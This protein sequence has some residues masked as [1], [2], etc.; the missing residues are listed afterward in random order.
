MDRRTSRC[1]IATTSARNVSGDKQLPFFTMTF[2]SPPFQRRLLVALFV[3]V[4]VEK[5]AGGSFIRPVATTRLPGYQGRAVS[6]LQSGGK[7]IENTPIDMEKLSAVD[8]EGP[9]RPGDQPTVVQHSFEKEV[10]RNDAMLAMGTS[11]R[12]IAISLL[13]AGGIALAGN[14][15]GVT[16]LILQTMDENTVEATGLDTFYPRGDYKRVRTPDYTFVIPKDWVADTSLELAKSQR[17][18]QPL[19]YAINKGR[20]GVLPDCG[21]SVCVC[22]GTELYCTMWLPARNNSICH[23]DEC[24]TFLSCSLWSTRAAGFTRGIKA[25]YECFR[26]PVESRAGLFTWRDDENAHRRCRISARECD[27]TTSRRPRNTLG[28]FRE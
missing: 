18:A 11:P 28:R 10:T 19:D 24:L 25:Y 14:L 2:S 1:D 16:S 4:F 22:V 15:F 3:F 27:W 23:A 6:L 5:C 20:S 12:R 17:M 13:S 21:K 8:Q 7:D 9:S 26:H